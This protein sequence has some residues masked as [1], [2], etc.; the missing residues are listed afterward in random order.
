MWRHRSF[1]KL[2]TDP[3]LNQDVDPYAHGEKQLDPDPQKMNADRP[4]TK[5]EAY[6][7]TS[8]WVLLKHN[9]FHCTSVQYTILHIKVFSWTMGF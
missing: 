3:H 9:I 1:V 6:T 2:E 7:G 8:Q 5:W 4:G